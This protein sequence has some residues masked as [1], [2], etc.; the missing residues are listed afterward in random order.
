MK[1]ERIQFAP[2]ISLPPL[3]I[4]RKFWFTSYDKAENFS[5]FVLDMAENHGVEVECSIDSV[6]AR[7]TLEVPADVD[8]DLARARAFADKVAGIHADWSSPAEVS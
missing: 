8:G 1:P 4:Y 2:L 3:G 7:L 6:D 5:E